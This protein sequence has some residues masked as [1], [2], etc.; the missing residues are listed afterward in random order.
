[1][2]FPFICRR[3]SKTPRFTIGEKH[4][5][6]SGTFIC[7]HFY[8]GRKSKDNETGY[9]CSFDLWPTVSTAAAQAASFKACHELFWLGISRRNIFLNIHLLLLSVC[10]CKTRNYQNSVSS[11]IQKVYNST[12]IVTESQFCDGAS[13]EIIQFLAAF[14]RPF[15]FDTAGSNQKNVYAYPLDTLWLRQIVGKKISFWLRHHK[16]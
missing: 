2:N 5:F 10:L 1:M 13:V 16:F 7:W 6:E 4:L 8:E 15:A 3:R 12:R 11:F 14:L 9:L